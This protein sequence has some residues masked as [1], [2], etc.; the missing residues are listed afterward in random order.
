MDAKTVYNQTRL[1]NLKRAKLKQLECQLQLQKK[2]G[3]DNKVILQ[4]MKDIQLVRSELA[5]LK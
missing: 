4:T 3:A 5:N 1:R 2:N